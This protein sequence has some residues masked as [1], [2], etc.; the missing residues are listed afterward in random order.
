MKQ[1]RAQQNKNSAYILR[2]PAPE[3]EKDSSNQF[4]A[5]SKTSA[6]YWQQGKRLFR[7]NRKN[8]EGVQVQ[9]ADYSCQISHGGR[10][11]QFQLHTPNKAAAASKAATIYR[12]VVGKG[13]EEAIR[14]HKPKSVPKIV[15]LPE[16]TVG[17]L[18]NAS[19]RLSSA[20]AE[21]MD[22]YAKALRRITAG[23]FE[24]SEGKKYDAFKGGRTAW[25]E[26]I[27]GK[28]L[29]ELTPASVLS[30]RNRYMKKART[31]EERGRAAVTVNSLIRNAKSLISKKI[32]R[33]IEQEM[34][35]PSPLFF[36]GVSAEAEPSLR[37][38]SKINA[39]EILKA[40]QTEL[41][42]S[43]PEAFKLL[44]LTLICG[45]RR[46]EA[47]TLLWRQFNFE[48][49]L[50]IIEDTEHKRL[51]SKDSA[52]DID[53]EPELCTLFQRLKGGTKSVFVLESPKG[54]RIKTETRKSRGYRCNETHHRVLLWLRNHGVTGMRPMH[55]LRKEIGSVIAS[56]D[57]I[58]K[59]SRYL[60][61]S[62]IRI[63]SKLYADKKIPVTAGFGTLLSSSADKNVDSDP[64]DKSKG[65]PQSVEK[66][67]SDGMK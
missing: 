3:D 40:A 49:G 41:A 54:I 47:D 51:K 15:S 28:P 4:A 1:N 33:F 57:G 56:R 17:S 39:E 30:W 36:E 62:D 67:S 13:W 7:F 58:W 2:T 19:M 21:T 27:D 20:R 60:R 64:D 34:I 6:N 9:D 46:S 48:K 45:L 26:K 52:G 59:A 53:L 5:R 18:I 10:R 24:I 37:Y 61:H 44:L 22:A 29:S 50:L 43:D 38:R 12:D 63:T 66:F 16:A 23:V 65:R 35:L 42:E 25:L 8:A 55:T 11:V 14:I 31:Q 32:R